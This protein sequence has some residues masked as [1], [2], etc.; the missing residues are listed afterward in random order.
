M[1]SRGGQPETAPEAVNSEAVNS[2]VVVPEVSP[3]EAMS[4]PTVEVTA[5]KWVEIP[6]DVPQSITVIPESLIPEE[7]SRRDESSL[8]F[9]VK[10]GHNAYEIVLE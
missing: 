4:L 7:Y 2:E 6:L 8:E 10:K 3:D 1:R 5:R 9:E